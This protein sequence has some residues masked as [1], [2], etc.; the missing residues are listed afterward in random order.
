[1]ITTQCRSV[2]FPTLSIICTNNVLT[3]TDFRNKFGALHQSCTPNKEREL[4]SM[5]RLIPLIDPV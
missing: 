1:M 2:C 3:R 4:Y 5:R